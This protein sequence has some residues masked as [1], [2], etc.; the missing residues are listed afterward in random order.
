VIANPTDTV[1]LRRILNVPKRGI[2]DRAEACVAQLAER[3]RIP[4]VAALGR[5]SRRPGHRHPVGRRDQAS[6][7]CWRAA[8]RFRGRIRRGRPARGVLEQSGYLRELRASPDPQDETRV[9][10]LAELVAVAQEF[11][12]ARAE[13]GEVDRAGRLP[14]AGLARRRRRRDPRRPEDEAR[15]AWSP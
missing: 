6:P 10:N 1:N 9:E 3:E 14:R 11:D 2:G 7:G 13:T 4:F 12:E 15:R 5:A 8:H